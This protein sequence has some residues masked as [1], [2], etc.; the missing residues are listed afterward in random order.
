MSLVLYYSPISPPARACLFTIRKLNLHVTV[1]NVDLF[2]SEQLE[3]DFVKL[4][5][6]AKVPVLMDDGFVVCESRAIMAYLV[7]AKKPGHSLY[8]NNPKVRAK[9]DEQ[10]Y[11]DA[12]VIF[13]DNADVIRPIFTDDVKIIPEKKEKKIMENMAKLDAMLFEKNWVA[14]VNPSIAD[15][16]I[17]SNIAQIKY[18]GFDF[19]H[20]TNI[21]AWYQRCKLLP[22]FDE[23]EAGAKELGNL[24]KDRI[25][26]GF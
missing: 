9:I 12:T 11:Y 16:S 5:P 24:F 21:L 26:Q 7:N 18:C 4:N 17:L 15:I 3:D 1:I 25:G 13:E 23:N 14:S 8:P 20:Y 19:S 6:V 2:A 22:G 10:L